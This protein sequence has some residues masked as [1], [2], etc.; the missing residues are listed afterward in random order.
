MH[1]GA[2]RFLPSEFGMDVDRMEHAIPPGDAIFAEK[3]RVRRAVE[4]AGIPHTYV[5]ANCFA[6]KFLAGL[7]QLG[8]FVPPTDR[9]DIYGSGDKKN[10]WVDELDVATCAML[11]AADPRALNKVLYVRPPAN[12]LSQMEVVKIWEELIGKELEKAYV[13]EDDW[14]ASMEGTYPNSS[15]LSLIY[16]PS[17]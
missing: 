10:V 2:Q 8:T 9:V 7:A 15:F 16:D 3:R 13:E 14:L 5:S 4:A 12:V 11:A 17:E 6:G 1:G